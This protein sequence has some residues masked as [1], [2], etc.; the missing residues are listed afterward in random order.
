MFIFSLTNIDFEAKMTRVYALALV[1]SNYFTCCLSVIAASDLNAFSDN[2]NEC[3][4]DHWNASKLLEQAPE[5]NGHGLCYGLKPEGN[6]TRETVF[7]VCYDTVN[8]I[9]TFTAH[10][11]SKEETAVTPSKE[12]LF[13]RDEAGPFSKLRTFCLYIFFLSNVRFT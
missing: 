12:K 4:F 3:L 1:L 7:A 2:I 13:F 6:H 10:I 11:V 9:P 5:C 8:L